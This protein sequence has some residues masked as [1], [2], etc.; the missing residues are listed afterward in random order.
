MNCELIE[1]PIAGDSEHSAYYC[2]VCRMTSEGPSL[3]ASG[4]S[5]M[6][7]T[8]PAGV[9]TA[10]EIDAFE[11]KREKE[12]GDITAEIIKRTGLAVAYKTVRAWVR[13]IPVSEVV[14]DGCKARQEWLNDVSRRFKRWWN[15]GAE[16]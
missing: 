14:C 2:P 6:L 4:R 12:L 3:A 7:R 1:L 11:A 9:P 5:M 16:T 8:C 15:A 10:A 13:D